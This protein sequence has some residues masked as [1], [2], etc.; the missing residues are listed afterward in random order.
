MKCTTQ[1]KKQDIDRESPCIF[2]TNDRMLGY[3]T[4]INFHFFTDIHKA[5]DSCKTVTGY[6]Y[7]QLFVLD[8]E[9]VYTVP[10]KKLGRFCFEQK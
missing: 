3:R 2:S 7:C 6:L 1:L 5:K 8:K 9:F 10:M 4:I